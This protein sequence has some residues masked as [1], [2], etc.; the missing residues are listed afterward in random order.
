MSA[1]VSQEIVSKSH[2]GVHLLQYQSHATY[3]VPSVI[4]L[5][6]Q[7]NEYGSCIASIKNKVLLHNKVFT[8]LC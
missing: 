5:K 8:H 2:E 1:D 4:N 7:S 6:E 3:S